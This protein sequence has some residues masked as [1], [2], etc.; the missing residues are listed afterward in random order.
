MA[1]VERRAHVV[2]EGDLA[3]GSGRLIE[4]SSKVIEEAAVTFASR[5]ERPDGKTN[6]EELIASAT[7]PAMRWRCPIPW[8]RRMHRRCGSR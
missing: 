3:S 5:V 1:N 4:E 7:P 2:W 6:P 8:P